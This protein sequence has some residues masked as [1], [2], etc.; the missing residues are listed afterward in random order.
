[1]KFEE[2]LAAIDAL[3]DAEGARSEDG[4]SY[5]EMTGRDCWRDAF[6]DGLSPQDAW[7]EEKLA[8]AA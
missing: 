2:W 1:M 7:S 6:D 8:G 4:R 5:T 3:S